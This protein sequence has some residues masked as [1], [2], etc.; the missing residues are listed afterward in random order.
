MQKPQFI[1]INL[2]VTKKNNKLGLLRYFNSIRNQFVEVQFFDIR[3]GKTYTY[4]VEGV[5]E[6]NKDFMKGK[7]LNGSY[8]LKLVK[9]DLEKNIENYK[10]N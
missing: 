3:R 1:K 10:K 7:K 9:S 4:K 5:K 8:K 2:P 6:F